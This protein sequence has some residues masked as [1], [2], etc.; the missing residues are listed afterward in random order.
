MKYGYG[1]LLDADQKPRR[2]IFY[3]LQV[4]IS[5]PVC[6]SKCMMAWPFLSNVSQSNPVYTK[7][8]A[9]QVVLFLSLA[10][11]IQVAQ[12]IRSVLLFQPIA[13]CIS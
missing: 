4:L 5:F 3:W 9:T 10:S 13:S 12:S 7:N 1:N 11:L 2:T 8:G 6:N